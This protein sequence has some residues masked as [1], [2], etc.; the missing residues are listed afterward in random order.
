MGTDYDVAVVGSGFAG[1]IL[2]MITRRLGR[3]VILI[4]RGRHPRFA[5]GESSTPL[6]NLLLEEIAGRYDLPRLRPLT[7]WGTWQRAH[8]EIGCGLK[9]GFTFYQHRSGELFPPDLEHERQLLVAASPRDEIADTHWYRPDFDEFLVREAQGMGVEYVDETELE[10]PE[11]GGSH[12]R[13]RGHRK[14]RE[15]DV[16][17]KFLVDATG[18]RGFLF[19]T[20]PLRERRVMPLTEALFSHFEG[21][22]PFGEQIGENGGD[23]IPPYP[24]D[25]AAV[26]HLLPGGWIWVLRFNNGV[27]SAGI[28]ARENEARRFRF[29]EGEAA[30]RRVLQTVP[31]VER[32]F[33][34]ARAVQP[35]F[36]ISKLSFCVGQAAGERWALLP[37]A[38]GF[39]D[40]LLSTGFPLALLG[41]SRLAD[42]MER[43]WETGGFGAGLEPYSKVTLEEIERTG[44]L[45]AAMYGNLERFERFKAL[46]LLYF[47]AASYSETVRRLGKP[48]CAGSFLLGDHPEFGPGLRECCRMALEE[49]KV[50]EDNDR[51]LAERVK[52]LIQKVDVAGLSGAGRRNWYPV[53]ASDLINAAP[54]LGVGREEIGELLKRTGF[55][56]GT[57]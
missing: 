41:V 37:S 36:H 47:A 6:A 57:D 18:P 49:G 43:E 4:E 12:V 55:G 3:S 50:G 11:I 21:V 23:A 34:A 19:R 28:A 27:T 20:L 17:A 45:I 35:F 46:S 26:H 52:E 1:S 31:S 56:S 39:I 24:V 8:P 22:T 48:E 14:G 53:L 25:D 30:W 16:T 5:I 2:A 33:A 38:A 40:P 42:L 32:T 15:I 54:K 13:L 51:R 44:E 10:R 29:E 9:R 7:K